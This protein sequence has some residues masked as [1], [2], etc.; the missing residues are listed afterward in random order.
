MSH[1]PNPF[2]FVP[3]AEEPTLKTIEEWMSFGEPRTGR[4]TVE[5]KAL[6]PVHIVGEQPMSGNNIQKSRFYRRG[7]KHYIPGSSMRGLLRAFV[8]AACNGWASQLTPYYEQEKTKHTYGFKVVNSETPEKTKISKLLS[9]NPSIDQRFCIPPSAEKG[10]DLASFLFG[11][12]PGKSDDKNQFNPAW[13]GRITIDDAEVAKS[14][15]SFGTKKQPH[16]IPDLNDSDAFMGGPH[17][18]ASSW[19]YQYPH[20]IEK[21]EIPTSHNRAVTIYRFIGSGFRGRKF[22]FHQDPVKS[23][24]AYKNILKW[25]LLNFFPVQCLEK[26]NCTTFD[27]FFNNIPEQLFKILLF[28]LEPGKRIRHKIGYGKA[29]GYG[30]I[31]FT[32]KDIFFQGKGFDK[33]S[34]DSVL[35]ATQTGICKQ[36]PGFDSEDKINIA[37]FLHRPSIE[38]LSFILWYEESLRCTYAYPCPGDGGFNVSQQGE[39]RQEYNRILRRAVSNTL[40]KHRFESNGKGVIMISP[41]QGKTVAID[42]REIK[43]ALH[44]EVYQESSENDKG[45]RIYDQL[46]NERAFEY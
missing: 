12:I 36:L 45:I 42:L 14:Q 17:P 29:H 19:W 27:I 41:K 13:K 20:A 44:F 9:N 25:N 6:T 4:I 10:I 31:E 1:N 22:Y 32:I 8:E 39:A 30:S 26:G 15:L 40:T 33:T 37:Q 21:D 35:N 2:D 16:E 43:P 24:Q 7:D 11:Y 23:I 34:K 18:S 3:F 38:A 28:A 5:M 46:K